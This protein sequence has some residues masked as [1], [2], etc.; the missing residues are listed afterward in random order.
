MGRSSDFALAA[1]R[2]GVELVGKPFRNNWI[3]ERP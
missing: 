2:S 1:M 3:A